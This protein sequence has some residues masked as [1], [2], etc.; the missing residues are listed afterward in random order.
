[1]ARFDMSGL[2]DV[3]RDMERMGEK[4][5]DVAKAMLFAGAEKVKSAWRSAVESHG[6]VDTGDMLESI[7][8]KRNPKKV[9]DDISVEI[10]PQGT[11]RKGVRNA[12]KAF[13]LHYGT[14]SRRGTR[15]VDDAD[16]MSESDA[17]PAME[18]V[19]GQFIET[20]SV[21]NV[22]STPNHPGGVNTKTI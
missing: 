11:D 9:G 20:G 4:S 13:I 6:L 7:G 15:F 18:A 16:R 1:M 14:S 3:I 19:W 10:Y 5:G 22:P 8:Y 17:I 21:P 2:E 12:E